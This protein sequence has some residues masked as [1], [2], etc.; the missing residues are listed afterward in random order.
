MITIFLAG[1]AAALVVVFLICSPT[2]RNYRLSHSIDLIE[3]G[4]K[5]T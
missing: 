5:F 1:I 2:I 4:T 3:T